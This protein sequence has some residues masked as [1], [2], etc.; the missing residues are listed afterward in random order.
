MTYI[1][2]NE[3]EFLLMQGDDDVIVSPSQTVLLHNALLETGAKATRYSL[4]GAGHASGDFDSEET[5]T[6]MADFIKKVIAS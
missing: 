5:L 6:V 1:D 4:T 3:P 2:G